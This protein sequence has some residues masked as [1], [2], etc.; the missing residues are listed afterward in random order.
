MKINLI[1]SLMYSLLVLFTTQAQAARPII[2]E[3]GNYGMGQPEAK[4]T[5]LGRFMDQNVSGDEALWTHQANFYCRFLGHSKRHPSTEVG[6]LEMTGAGPAI[7]MLGSKIVLTCPFVREKTLLGYQDNVF[8]GVKVAAALAIGPDVGIF[9]N[10][11][12]GVCFLTGI[13]LGV[14]GG[15]TFD[16]MEFV[17]EPQ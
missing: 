5:A 6:V 2:C 9:S 17:G 3:S 11:R 16:Q 12:L 15:V 8:R 7:Q 10:S 14:G 4:P 13:S 1:K